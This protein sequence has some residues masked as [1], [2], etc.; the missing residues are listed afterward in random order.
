MANPGAKAAKMRVLVA[1]SSQMLKNCEPLQTAKQFVRR[2]KQPGL[3]AAAVAAKLLADA[4]LSPTPKLLSTVASIV[5]GAAATEAREVTLVSEQQEALVTVLTALS[6]QRPLLI[7]VED[8]GEN[9]VLRLPCCAHR[10]AQRPT[11]ARRS[12][13]PRVRYPQ[14]ISTRRV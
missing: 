7:A 3:A 9:A 2:W 12:L 14:N 11:G 6:R 1:Q 13:V 10:A 4:G 5:G 8:S